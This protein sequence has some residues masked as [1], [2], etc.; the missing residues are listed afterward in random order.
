MRPDPPPQTLALTPLSRKPLAC[1][2]GK[3]VAIR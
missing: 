2:G 1:K 3:D